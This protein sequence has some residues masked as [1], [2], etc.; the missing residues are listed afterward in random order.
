MDVKV[1]LAGGR[2]PSEGRVEVLMEVGGRKQWGAVCSE[3]WGINEAMVVCR[4][5][6]MGFAASAHEVNQPNI[7]NWQY[8]VSISF[9]IVVPHLTWVIKMT[10][11]APIF[12]V[13]SGSIS[14]IAPHFWTNLC[15][16]ENV[17]LECSEASVLKDFSNSQWCLHCWWNNNFRLSAH[18]LWMTMT[19]DSTHS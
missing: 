5:L 15:S 11:H 3:N 16:C 4:Q 17:R 18:S 12:Q 19:Y 2:V 1:R 10:P 13:I 9:L 14:S 7:H 6:G 8:A